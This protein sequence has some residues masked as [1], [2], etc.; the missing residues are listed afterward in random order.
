[1]SE[2]ALFLFLFVGPMLAACSSE[3][4]F[5]W[6]TAHDLAF[7]RNTGEISSVTDVLEYEPWLLTGYA[8]DLDDPLDRSIAVAVIKAHQAGDDI[9]V[10]A[11]ALLPPG[12]DVCEPHCNHFEETEVDEDG[13][14]TIPL[15]ECG[16]CDSLYDLSLLDAEEAYNE[17]EFSKEDAAELKDGW[18]VIDPDEGLP[19]NILDLIINGGKGRGEA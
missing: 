12:Y 17:P 14:W 3:S 18:T 1:M 5:I 16:V 9:N 10:A 6:G 8:I 15:A 19:D 11:A 2:L 13:A 7:I 4:R